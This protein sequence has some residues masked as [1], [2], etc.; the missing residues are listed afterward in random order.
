MTPTGSSGGKRR[1]RPSSFHGTTPAARIR[2]R[3]V[4]CLGRFPGFRPNPLDGR[5]RREYSSYDH[6]PW[7]CQRPQVALEQAPREAWRLASQ[8]SGASVPEAMIP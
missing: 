3:G 2:T 8:L 7:A 1:L 4:R 5:A 6:R